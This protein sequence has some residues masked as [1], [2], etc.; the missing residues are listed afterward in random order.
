MRLLLLL[1]A[2]ITLWTV[3]TA[4]FHGRYRKAVWL[5]IDRQEKALQHKAQH[6]VEFF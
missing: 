2:I 1:I 6:A 4:E 3:D 5:E